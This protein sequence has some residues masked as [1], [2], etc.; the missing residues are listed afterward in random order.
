MSFRIAPMYKPPIPEGWEN[1]PPD[2]A[3]FVSLSYIIESMT[4]KSTDYSTLRKMVAHKQ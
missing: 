1:W 4:P 3:I 2:A